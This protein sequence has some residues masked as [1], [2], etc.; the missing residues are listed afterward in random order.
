MGRARVASLLTLLWSAIQAWS[1]L[2][3]GFYP[4]RH[5][6]GWG[7][8]VLF[9]AISVGLWLAKPWARVSFLI[10]GTGF[11][12]FYATAYYF[13]ALPCAT[14]SSTCNMSLVLSQPLLT[15]ATLAILFKPLAS[16]PTIERDARKSGA[17]PSL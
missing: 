17:R 7:L 11:V 8:C 3:L 12:I 9:L 14:D 2:L 1:L 6:L 4:A 16:N 10:L 13:A 5:M 15:F